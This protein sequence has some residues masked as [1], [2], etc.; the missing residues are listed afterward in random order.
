[1]LVVHLNV[2]RH[3]L[4]FYFYQI[5]N[6]PIKLVAME[7]SFHQAKFEFQCLATSLGLQS[8]SVSKRMIY[9]YITMKCEH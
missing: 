5:L 1:M 2:R 7:W 6:D 8:V 9:I 4:F 3:K